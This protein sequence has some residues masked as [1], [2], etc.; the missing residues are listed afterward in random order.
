MITKRQL[1]VLWLMLLTGLNL[2]SAPM[3]VKRLGIFIGANDGGRER[4]R[5]LYA[6]DDALKM[7]RTMTDIGGI[8]PSDSI[9]LLDPSAGEIKRELS[10]IGDRING[11]SAFARRTE[12]M[13]YYSGHSDE[14]GIMIQD[15]MISYKEIRDSLNSA[16]ADVIIAILDSCS[17][18]AITRLKGGQRRSPFLIDDSSSMEGHAFLTSSSA[19]ELSQESD[20][21]GASFFTHYLISGL[22]GAADSTGDGRVTLNEIYQH[23]FDETLSQTE[24][25]IGGPQHPAYEIQLTGTGDL[26][27]TDLTVPTAALQL[28]GELEGRFSV[29]NS[30][31]RLVAE[32]TK[33]AGEILKLAL[34]AGAYS[35]RQSETRRESGNE[36]Y[37]AAAITLNRNAQLYLT[38]KHFTPINAEFTRYRGDEPQ[39]E[40]KGESKAVFTPWPGVNLPE[41]EEG[42]RV[43]FQ[44]GLVGNKAPYLEGVQL[45][46]LWNIIEENA[47]GIQGGIGFNQVSGNLN[48][49]QASY[50]GA[51]IVKG[52]LKG[53]QAAPVFNITRGEMQG[54]QCTNIFN[55]SKGGMTG[56]QGAGLFNIAGRPSAGI[57]GAGLF[58]VAGEIHGIQ[59]AGLFNSAGYMKGVQAS[60][61]NR[62]VSMHG[63]Q[64]GLINV[65]RE[66]RGV[67]VGLINISRNGIVDFGGWYE[68]S[69]DNRIFLSFQSG[70]RWLYTMFYWGNTIDGFF[71]SPDN[72]AWGVSLGTRIPLG[73]LEFDLDAGFRQSYRDQI[74]YNSFTAIPSARAI[75]ALKG[76]GLFWGVTM[77]FEIP[78][79]RASSLHTG[80]S[81]DFG[82]GGDVKGYYNYIFGIRL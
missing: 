52:D 1:P 16:G 2:F 47:S 60:L 71:S 57:Q 64:V 24:S 77:D 15:E 29:R 45:A 58:N 48:G 10:R 33:P 18:G 25:T 13:F 27:L 76:I 65:S 78:G 22:R 69:D 49:L 39:D 70:T 5:L 14:N 54:V 50:W 20:R 8:D 6:G 28:S 38:S 7:S 21:I 37:M 81:T 32:F 46:P 79:I 56:V 82:S 4:Q 35:I 9:L 53:M 51:N 72:M 31:D 34:P 41:L 55:Y 30:S 75:V 74:D 67:P 26:V 36:E 40:E 61:I 59:G 44:F 66:I 68:Y 19:T 23:T 43:S 3:E 42:D 80:P 63:L 73:F 12:V 11:V 62:A 17:S